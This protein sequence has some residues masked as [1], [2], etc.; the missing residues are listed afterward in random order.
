MLATPCCDHTRTRASYAGTVLNMRLR[1]QGRRAR[2]ARLLADLATLLVVVGI[3]A[4]M[5]VATGPV[6]SSV[7]GSTFGISSHP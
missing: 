5:T 2:K 1:M 3:A 7:T 4:L 6:H